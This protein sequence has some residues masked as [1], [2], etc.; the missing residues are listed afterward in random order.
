MRVLY[1]YQAFT[2]QRYGG[3]SNCFAQLI[4]NMPCNVECEVSVCECDN[5][6]LR[7]SHI[8]DVPLMK[9]YY[10]TFI[11]NKRFRYQSHL[12]AIYS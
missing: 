8:T 12:Y 6:H 1:D 2:M 9:D 10:D 4:K 11:S 3:V 5:V 7:D